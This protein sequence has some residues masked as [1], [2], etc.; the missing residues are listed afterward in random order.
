M[1]RFFTPNP[2]FVK[3][4][5]ARRQMVKFIDRKT[6]KVFENVRRF[7]PIDTR[8]YIDSLDHQTDVV[9]G[10]ALGV[11]TTTSWKW[12]FIE[13]GTNDTPTFAPLRK[14]LDATP[15]IKVVRV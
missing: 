12:H 7:A 1:G 3:K 6:V 5:A 14:G 11:V 10:R 2:Q 15:G 13:F 9:N 8:D 4:V